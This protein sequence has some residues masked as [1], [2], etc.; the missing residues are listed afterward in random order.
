MHFIH[1]TTFILSTNKIKLPKPKINANQV[2]ALFPVSKDG[3]NE[4]SLKIKF[5]KDESRSLKEKKSYFCNFGFNSISQVFLIFYEF[6]KNH[7][8]NLGQ[9]RWQEVG[10][11][12]RRHLHW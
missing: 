9:G 6:N 12:Y 10:H 1:F 8:G 7:L 4:L 2:P 11:L 5:V 3:L